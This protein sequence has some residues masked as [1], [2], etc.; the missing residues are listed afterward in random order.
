MCQV[1]DY[2]AVVNPTKSYFACRLYSGE[3]ET[4]EQ[5]SKLS[6]EGATQVARRGK[7][8]QQVQSLRGGSVLPKP[9][10]S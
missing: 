6:E 7:F 1:T 2:N 5:T 8:H 9:Q 10:S 3:V 4:V